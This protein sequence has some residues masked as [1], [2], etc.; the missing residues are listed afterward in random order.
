ML[1]VTKITDPDKERVVEYKQKPR[2]KLP[3]QPGSR[4]LHLGPG[5]PFLV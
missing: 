3:R 5:G 2:L 1:W 4:Q